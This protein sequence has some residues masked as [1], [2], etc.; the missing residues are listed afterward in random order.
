MVQFNDIPFS[1]R[2]AKAL[3]ELKINY[4]FQPIF[5]P[6]GKTVYA[7]EA[8]MRPIDMTITE[9]IYEYTRRNELYT[10]EVATVFG[11]LKE[12]RARGYSELPSLNSFPCEMFSDEE[13]RAFNEYFEG[14]IP[15]FIVETLEYPKFDPV[16]SAQKRKYIDLSNNLLALDDFDCGVNTV[17]VVDFMNPDIIK[18]DRSL[19]TGIDTDVTKQKNCHHIIH[20]AHAKGIKI[21]AEGTETKGEVDCL[22]QL[23]ADFF[24]GFYLGM[25]T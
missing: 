18:L 5:Y 22:K 3:S 14:N 6:D 2:M 20:T 12:F 21:V 11:A 9:L 19:L 16:I 24:Q 1:P 25:P 10:L 23:V 17:E 13:N 8:L 4:V 15:K 7:R